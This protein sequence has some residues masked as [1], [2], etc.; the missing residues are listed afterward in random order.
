[1][2]V[3]CCYSRKKK[4]QTGVTAPLEICVF[5]LNIQTSTFTVS[6][7]NADCNQKGQFK[8]T[9]NKTLHQP[10]SVLR[11]KPAKTHLQRKKM[12]W[13]W[14]TCRSCG[15]SLIVI[16]NVYS[17]LEQWE[18]FTSIIDSHHSICDCHALFVLS[19]KIIHKYGKDNIQA[20]TTAGCD[21]SLNILSAPSTSCVK[22]RLP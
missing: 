22:T 1:M 15:K 3:F 20:H 12:S 16:I 19:I 13:F 21:Q 18:P 5:N 10:I 9:Q 17:C 7:C 2:W 8:N 6:A 14:Y 11:Q 4:N